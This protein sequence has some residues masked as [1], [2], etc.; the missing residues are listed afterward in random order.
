M[1]KCFPGLHRHLL[2]VLHD[3]GNKGLRLN[4]LSSLVDN[5]NIKPA[6]QRPNAPLRLRSRVHGTTCTEQGQGRSLP[7]TLPTCMLSSLPREAL[8][9]RVSSE[10]KCGTHNASLLEDGEPHTVTLNAI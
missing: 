1:R 10:G 6:R 5:D 3:H 9:H 7:A 2:A 4:S 8:K